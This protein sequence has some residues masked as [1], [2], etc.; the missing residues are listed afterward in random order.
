VD[1][2]ETRKFRGR[3]YVPVE[4]AEVREGD[5]VDYYSPTPDRSRR[6]HY[7]LSGLSKR[8][9]ITVGTWKAEGGTSRKVPV[10]DVVRAWRRRTSVGAK[11]E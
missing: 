2:G 6:H 7:V 11:E 1:E 9:L 8:G 4:P 3:V 5:V 10:Q